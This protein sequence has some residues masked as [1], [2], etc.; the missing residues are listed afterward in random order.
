[1]GKSRLMRLKS[2]RKCAASDEKTGTTS[3][4]PVMDLF[5]EN[6]QTRLVE[7]TFDS[8]K[9]VETTAEHPFYIQGKGWNP[10]G[11]LKVGQALL[12]HDGTTVV[13]E[14]VDSSARREVVFNFSVANAHNYF[15]G[16][17]GV[18]VHNAATGKSK[19]AKRTKRKRK[20]KGLYERGSFRKDPTEDAIAAATDSSGN[21]ICPTCGSII[22]DFITVGKR[23]RRGFDLDHY[24]ET[25]AKRVE[26]MKSC[27]KPP[28][29]KEVLDEYNR[30]LRVQCPE[31][32]QS[33]QW[34]GIKGPYQK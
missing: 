19:T 14:E 6:K 27:P 26:K 31:C 7:I 25:W 5:K 2:V 8:G 34:E 13:V 11:S 21:R 24:P 9:K 29:R 18:L 32:N 33:H 30:D 17:D 28:T 15:V 10:A 16:G 22:P 12:L 23:T 1:M 20:S 3:F 4:Q